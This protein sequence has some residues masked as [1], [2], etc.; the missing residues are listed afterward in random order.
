M[1]ISH[2]ENTILNETDRS[3]VAVTEPTESSRAIIRSEESDLL[4]SDAA[5]Y[6]EYGEG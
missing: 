4:Y 5:D 2:A 3:G 1:Q 6:L